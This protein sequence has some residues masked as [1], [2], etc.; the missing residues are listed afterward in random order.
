MDTSVVINAFINGALKDGKVKSRNDL[1]SK[2]GYS[3]SSVL[4]Q[5]INSDVRRPKD[6]FK[7]MSVALDIDE[8]LL[9]GQFMNV[10][11]EIS[12]EN[13]QLK[14][15]V[16]SLTKEL[17]KVREECAIKVKQTKEL[18]QSEIDEEIN[19]GRER[20]SELIDSL[21]RENKMYRLLISS[22]LGI[23]I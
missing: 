5:F 3:S 19:K 4:S 13:K 21:R 22:K 10:A 11:E 8:R 14:E 15:Q 20:Y 9:T 6:F 17:E 18:Y 12:K 16:K 1:A 2:M 7:K 23:D